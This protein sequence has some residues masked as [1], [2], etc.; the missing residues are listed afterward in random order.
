MFRVGVEVDVR[1]AAQ[2]QKA[3]IDGVD[4]DRRGEL[5][6]HPAHALREVA[7][8]RHVAREDR[9]MVL[10]YKVANLEERITHLNAECFCFVRSRNGAAVVAR[11]NNDG[12]ALQVGT[13]DPL[14]GGEEVV[15]VGQGEHRYIFLM[16]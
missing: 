3:L 13:K 16:T 12:L 8:E 11:E 14:A 1:H 5:L 10:G 4:L 2:I 6:Q 7:I 15:A 9:D